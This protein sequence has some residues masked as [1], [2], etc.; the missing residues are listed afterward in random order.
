MRNTVEPRP[1]PQCG[2]QPHIVRSI[3]DMPY[4]TCF[5]HLETKACATAAEAVALWN[6]QQ[7]EKPAKPMQRSQTS[8][9]DE[10]A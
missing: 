2:K 4:V 7:Y 9:L 1:C 10:N 6:A 5:G 3:V 8:K